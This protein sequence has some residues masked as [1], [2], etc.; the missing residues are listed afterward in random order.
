MLAVT[1]VLTAGGGVAS[2]A[3]TVVNF[4]GLEAGALVK[5]Q[6]E[7]QGLKLGSAA[8]L[9]QSSPGPGDCGAPTV[10]TGG[11]APAQSPPNYAMLASCPGGGSTF[12][13][14]FGKLLNDPPGPLSVYVSNVVVGTPSAQVQLIAYDS[15]GHEIG[16]ETGEASTAGWTRITLNPGAAKVGFFLLRTEKAL[17]AGMIAID[18]LGLQVPQSTPPSPETPPAPPP[19]PPTPVITLL[20]PSPHSGQPVTLSGAGSEPGSGH[21]ISYEWDFNG[22]GRIDTSTGTNPVARTILPSGTH[23]IGLT[24][25]NSN[26]QKSSTHFGLVVQGITL[27]PQPDGGKGRARRALKW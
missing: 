9:G 25:T 4:D 10:T 5:S 3:E 11:A 24:V 7:G 23:T 26:G 16:A 17:A 15:T 20:T 21:V 8:E 12:K 6:Y 13:G 1:A 19:P 2:A 18:D 27:P 22:D 14:T